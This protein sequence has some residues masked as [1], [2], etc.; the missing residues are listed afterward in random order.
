M[1]QMKDKF[2]ELRE[3]KRQLRKKPKVI[4]PKPVVVKKEELDDLSKAFL[5]N[6]E[7]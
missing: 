1:K 7:R 2:D 6:L 4:K 5:E 3:L